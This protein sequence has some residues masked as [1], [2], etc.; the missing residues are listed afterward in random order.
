VKKKYVALL[1]VIA[2]LVF[3]ASIGGALAYF[4]TYTTAMGGYPVAL[5]NNP[6]PEEWYKDGL[7]HLTIKN[8]GDGP[9]FVRAKAVVTD[10]VTPEYQESAN[11]TVNNLSGA[12]DGAGYYYYGKALEG[13]NAETEAEKIT[14]ELLIKI[15]FP[16]QPKIEGKTKYEIGDEMNVLVLFESVPAMY[17]ADG[18]ED[19]ALAWTTGPVTVVK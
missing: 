6:T 19:F 16:T 12:D 7:K 3:S 14:S 13:K 9:I 1:I 15:T 17:K 5:D 11:W 2:A 18:T 4:S 8:T 10:G